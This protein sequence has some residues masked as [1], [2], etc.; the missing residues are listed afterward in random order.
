MGSDD[1][2][3]VKDNENDNENDKG[4]GKSHNKGL[5]VWMGIVGMPGKCTALAVVEAISLLRS[6]S[7][8]MSVTADDPSVHAFFIT[9][10]SFHSCSL[11]LTLVVLS[12]FNIGGVGASA[13]KSFFCSHSH[14]LESFLIKVSAFVVLVF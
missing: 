14:T 2:T 5:T 6:L 3:K 4:N 8:P 10:F 13:S 12:S 9:H 7:E 11:S 1:V